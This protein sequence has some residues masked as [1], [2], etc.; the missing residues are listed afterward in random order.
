MAYINC[1]SFPSIFAKSR[2]IHA[3]WK[4][5]LE[6]T[7]LCNCALEMVIGYD[8]VMN[9]WWSKAQTHRIETHRWRDDSWHPLA[10]WHAFCNSFRKQFDSIWKKKNWGPQSPS[11]QS[12]RQLLWF[13]ENNLFDCRWDLKHNDGPFSI[14]GYLKIQSDAENDDRQSEDHSQIQYILNSKG[15]NFLE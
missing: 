8:A 3:T 15:W 13:H 9:H 11:Q 5:M 2:D 4:Q 1:C 6:K 12:R 7:P 10:A 14:F